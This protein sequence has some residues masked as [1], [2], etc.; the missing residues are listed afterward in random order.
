M[1]HIPEILVGV[2]IIL[3]AGGIGAVMNVILQ[4]RDD[5]NHIK[6]ELSLNGKHDTLKDRVVL[7]QGQMHDVQKAVEKIYEETV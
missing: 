3:I 6:Y 5:V 1:D 7:L 2:A 4:L